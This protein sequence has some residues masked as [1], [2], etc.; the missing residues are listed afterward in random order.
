MLEQINSY[1]LTY[2]TMITILKH[3]SLEWLTHDTYLGINYI[4]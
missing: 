2:L 3:K 1:N 4:M